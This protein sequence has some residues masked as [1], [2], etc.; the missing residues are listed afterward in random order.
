MVGNEEG[1]G[2]KCRYVSGLYCQPKCRGFGPAGTCISE[3]GDFILEGKPF[4]PDGDAKDKTSAEAGAAAGF[5]ESYRGRTLSV[6]S[7]KDAAPREVLP[8]RVVHGQP[9]QRDNGPQV[10]DGES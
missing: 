3:C 5:Y 8:D 7:P 4:S 1:N 2:N 6:E 9:P 10:V